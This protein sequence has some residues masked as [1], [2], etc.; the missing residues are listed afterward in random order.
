[1]S[2]RNNPHRCSRPRRLLGGGP[3]SA[4]VRSGRR[5]PLFVALAALALPGVARAAEL[6][7]ET[8]TLS[9]GIALVTSHQTSVPMVVVRVVIDAGSRYDPDGKGGLASLTADL[10]TEGTARRDASAIKEQVDF[11]GAELDASTNVDCA[12]VHL[13]IVRKEVA[14][15]VELLADLIRNP[16]FPEAEVAR[17]REAALA[18]IRSAEDDPNRVA[19]RVFRQAVYRGEP[20]GHPVEGTEQS[21]ATL[22]RADVV[23]FHRRYYRPAQT[24]VIVVGDLAPAEATDL[25]ERALGDWANPGGELPTYRP[26]PASPPERIVVEKPVPQAAVVLG[27]RGVRRDDPDFEALVV[28]NHILGG[29]GFGSRLLD[30]IRTEAGLA[31]SVT[32]FFGAGQWTGNF[33]V[34]LQTKNESVADAVGRVRAQIERIRNE[35]VSEAELEDARRYL[36]GSFPLRLDSNND[37]AAFLA[38]LAAFRLGFD[39]APRYLQRIA[40]VT[41]EDVRRVAREHLRPDELI[42]VIVGRPPVD[43]VERVE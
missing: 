12:S 33:Q 21:V 22:R 24:T 11:L 4:L 7:V 26:A 43:A 31:Y 37:I 14:A 15:G 23:S 41:R 36:T 8:A 18:A 28:M 6:R 25:F 30:D 39:Y 13:R 29:G 27:H 40:A 34:V 1:M 2:I 38:E 16:T 10:L 35:P 32:S 19:S 9:N 5:L 42:E 17:R 3:S 20:Y